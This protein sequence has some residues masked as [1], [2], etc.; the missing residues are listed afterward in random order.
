MANDSLTNFIVLM[1]CR[2]RRTEIPF[3]K[4]VW[5]PLQGVVGC[6]LSDFCMKTVS[7]AILPSG[8]GFSSDALWAILVHAPVRR[9]NGFP[10]TLRTGGWPLS[11]PY[12]Q[13]RRHENHFPSF[14]QKKCDTDQRSVAEK[15]YPFVAAVS[16]LERRAFGISRLQSKLR[17]TGRP[18]FAR[19]NY[20]QNRCGSPLAARR[21]YRRHFSAG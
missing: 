4:S 21:S 5:L 19:G 3:E 15:H 8:T 13:E 14:G 6:C 11:R 20:R 1:N 18:A 17:R 9:A 2:F 16:L 12:H 10:G 7:K